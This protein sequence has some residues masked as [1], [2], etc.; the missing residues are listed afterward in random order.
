MEHI[1]DRITLW[2]KEKEEEYQVFLRSD[3]ARKK[4]QEEEEP[5]EVEKKGKKGGRKAGEW[6]NT[7]HLLFSPYG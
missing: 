5:K 7:V 4:A 2:L 6:I 3:A 1:V